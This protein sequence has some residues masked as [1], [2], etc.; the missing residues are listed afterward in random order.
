[1]TNQAK[2]I[3]R[4]GFS[5]SDCLFLDTNVLIYIYYG[6]YREEDRYYKK[7]YTDA[8]GK[9]RES[10]SQIFIDALVLSEFINRFVH[11]EYDRLLPPIK[12]EK[13]KNNYKIFRASKDGKDAARE[14]VIHTHKILSYAQIC[15]LDYNF[16]K[17][18]LP[19]H[20]SEY[21]KSNS[22]FNDL[23]YIELCKKNDFT[24]VTH[25]GDFKNC[26]IPVLTANRNLL[27]N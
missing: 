6:I 11:M 2:D 5:N 16:I 1:M 12:R 23:L 25:D 27:D 20:L 24:L 3:R 17:P 22:D 10:N 8:L 4:S 18:G 14:I 15:D 7:W 21:E 9:M 19:N 26:G 13:N